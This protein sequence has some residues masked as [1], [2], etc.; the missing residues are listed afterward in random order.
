MLPGYI[1]IH[2]RH[3]VAK[4]DDSHDGG[5]D[6]QLSVNTEPREVQADLFPKVLPAGSEVRDQEAKVTLVEVTVKAEQTEELSSTQHKCED[7][8]AGFDP[9]IE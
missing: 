3:P 6:Q 9:K 1:S 7:P 8:H 5:W 4:H 2:R